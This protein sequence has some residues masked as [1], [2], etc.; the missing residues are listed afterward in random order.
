MTP[1]S[2]LQYVRPD[3]VAECWE[4]VSKAL[5]SALWRVTAAMPPIP[6]RE[7][8]GPA[9]HI[10]VNSV[11]EHWH[12]FTSDEKAELNRLAEAQGELAD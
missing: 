11:V 2:A 9:D 5:S 3:E 12:M 6:N 10:G 4:G 8:S 1:H 7:D